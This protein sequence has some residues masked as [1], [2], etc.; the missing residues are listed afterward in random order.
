MAWATKCDRC[1]KYFDW[2]EETNAFAFMV[3]D[4]GTDRYSVGDTEELDLCPDCIRSLNH[5]FQNP[6]IDEEADK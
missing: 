4:H 1:G 5:W 2:H 3:Y 6:C